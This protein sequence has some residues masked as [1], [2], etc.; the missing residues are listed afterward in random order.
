[1][2]AQ[3]LDAGRYTPTLTNGANVAASTEFECGWFRVGN[4]VTVSGLVNIDVTLTATSTVLG[5]SLPIPS[6]FTGGGQLSGVGF[7]QAIAGLGLGIN[8]E[9]TANEAN[10]QFISSDIANQTFRFIFSYQ[11]M[12]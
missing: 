4:T 2:D 5:M 11:V 10:L 12:A 3:L 6:D 9:T 7:C 8:A 1:M